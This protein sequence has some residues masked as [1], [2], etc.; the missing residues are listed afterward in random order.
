LRVPLETTRVTRLADLVRAGLVCTAAAFLLAGD[1]SVAVKAA[2][3]LPA[4]FAS[5][6]F[7]ASPLLDLVFTLALAAEA[8]GSALATHGLIGWDDRISHLV[9]PLLSGSVVYGALQRT[10]VP[11]RP[12]VA[13]LVTGAAVLAIAAVWEVVE[14]GVDATIGTNFSMGSAD[15]A[16]DLSTDA[17]AAAG[18]G[19][20]V[21]VCARRGAGVA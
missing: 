7:G 20:A 15:T 1:E 13:G 3:L 10:R 17:V 5:R 8:A 14:W 16:G 11:H 21:V 4:T 6:L 2:L 19:A 12:A 18:A 9:L